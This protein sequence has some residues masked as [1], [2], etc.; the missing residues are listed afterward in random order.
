MAAKFLVTG[1]AGFIGFHIT[2]KLLQ[3]NYK[4]IGFD[5][6]NK[7]YDVDLKKKRIENLNK[8]EKTSGEN[9]ETRTL[10]I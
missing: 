1:A 10:G 5:N 4:V 6:L 8:S 2:K 3:E 7:Y 9:W